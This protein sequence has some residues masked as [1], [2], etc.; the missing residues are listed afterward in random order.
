MSHE[1][2]SVT[3]NLLMRDQKMISKQ[4]WS[5]LAIYQVH[6]TWPAPNGN[7]R[8]KRDQTL[9]SLDFQ[10][11]WRFLGHKIKGPEEALDSTVESSDQLRSNW[12]SS[13]VTVENVSSL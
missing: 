3:L 7:W 12:D 2:L 1:T 13:V 4:I 8:M 10:F 5:R 6:T 9:W 11:N